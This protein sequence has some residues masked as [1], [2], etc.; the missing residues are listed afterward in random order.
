MQI[1]RVQPFQPK[2]QAQ[3]S[4]DEET[5]K[6][7][8]SYNNPYHVDDVYWSISD[9]NNI[10]SEDSISLKQISK[11]N[12]NREVVHR[13]KNERTGAFI[14]VSSDTRNNLLYN[15]GWFFRNPTTPEYKKLFGKSELIKY[16][17]RDENLDKLSGADKIDEEIRNLYL[18]NYELEG[19]IDQN[20]RK[21][22]NLRMKEQKI[23]QDYVQNLIEL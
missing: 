13:V 17:I 9:L 21:M 5:K 7:L 8:K 20:N 22:Q 12:K 6:I 14:D 23:R 18:K 16:G 15:I 11:K 10:D 3:Y 2:F 1:T 4:K 19:E